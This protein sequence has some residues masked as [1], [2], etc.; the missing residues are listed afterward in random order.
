MHNRRGNIMR[1]VWIVWGEDSEGRFIAGVYDDK[2]RAEA[3][4][5]MACLQ[6]DSGAR[7]W[8][9]EKEITK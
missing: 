4:M 7:Y 9:Q 2:V 1:Y 6:P 3:D 8:I 5:R